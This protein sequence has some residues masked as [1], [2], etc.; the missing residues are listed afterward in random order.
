MSPEEETLFVIRGAIAS[1][2]AED[3]KEV[4]AHAANFRDALQKD[5]RAGMALALV[6]AELAAQP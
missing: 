4:Q 6:G 5:S 3:Q 2:P 1:L